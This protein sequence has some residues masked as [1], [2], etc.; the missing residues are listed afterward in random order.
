MVE[1]YKVRSMFQLN[2]FSLTYFPPTMKEINIPVLLG[3]WAKNSTEKISRATKKLFFAE[4][5]VLFYEQL[6]TP[7]FLIN[8]QKIIINIPCLWNKSHI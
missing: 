8:A 1:K 6:C 4:G 7:Y 3:H 2:D 5:S